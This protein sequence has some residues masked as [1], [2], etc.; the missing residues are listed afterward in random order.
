MYKSAC[1]FMQRSAFLVRGHEAG[2]LYLEPENERP[3]RVG[4]IRPRQ[5]VP[6]ISRQP[7]APDTAM[8]R[9]MSRAGIKLR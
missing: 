4:K 5:E 3:L 7:S 2:R 1:R 8:A 6:A 9:A